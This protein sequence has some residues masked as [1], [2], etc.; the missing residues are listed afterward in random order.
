MTLSGTLDD[1]TFEFLDA[2]ILHLIILFPSQLLYP[3][4]RK[5]TA[6]DP[7][8][9]R[10]IDEEKRYQAAI[11]LMKGK[12][13]KEDTGRRYKIK[14]KDATSRIGHQPPFNNREVINLLKSLHEEKVGQTTAD[15]YRV[16]ISWWHQISG[17]PDPCDKQT[18]R[19]CDAIHRD[20]PNKGNP[21]RRPFST[22][23][24]DKII[25]YCRDHS[26]TPGDVW[27][28]NGTLIAL[29]LS[30]ALRI[31]D[32]LS[33]K[34]EDLRWQQNPIRLSV[35]I[36]DGKTDKFSVGKWTT[37][38]LQY[39]TEFNDGLHRLRE[40]VTRTK[41]ATGYIFRSQGQEHDP[42]SH[43][44][45]DTMR[46]TLLRIAERIGIKDITKI[47]WHSCRKTK[48]CLT[49]QETANETGK[50][51]SVRQVLGHTKKSTSFKY[52]LNRSMGAK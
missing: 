52:Y 26:K 32:M 23:E 12:S 5:E 24:A 40:F 13:L 10:N 15:V 47:G 14:I 18:A 50:E 34:Y 3:V 27:D 49:F 7:S 6:R 29:D 36:A 37:E 11:E 33:L 28:R 45:Y 21:A 42:A 43:V 41:E 4:E 44:T 8:T 2:K 38:F 35:W 17:Y 31:D 1:V 20:L 19:L 48:A 46:K 9:P 22:Q 16:A 25:Q 30:T 51:D 39:S